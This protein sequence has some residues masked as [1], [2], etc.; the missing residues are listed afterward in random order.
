MP[1]TVEEFNRQ[2]KALKE[3][4]AL[5]QE[6]KLKAISE[7]KKFEQ[8]NRI[9]YLGHD[10]KGYLGKYG[11]WRLNRPQQ[12]LTDKFSTG[13][14]KVMTY[15]GGNRAGKTF[16]TTILLLSCIMGR[17][18]W[19][20]QERMGWIW[21]LYGWTNPIKIRWVGQDW[22]QHIK[23]V[24][25]QTLKELLPK[26][27][28]VDTKKNNVGAENIWE[29]KI[30]GLP[31]GSIE[32]MSNNSDSSVFEGAS[33]HVAAYDEP[34]SRDVRIA[35]ARGL[36]DN[37]GIELFAMT[38]L[39][40]AWV[41]HDIIEKVDEEGNP[42]QTVY[43]VHAE[44]YDNV[45]LGISAEG[46]KQFAK[47]LTDD[48]Q[49]I[50]LKGIP[51]Y[52]QGLVLPIKREVH[53]VDK[54]QIPLHWPVDIS[55]D[56]H[57]KKP[58][59]VLFM[60]TSPQNLKYCFHEIAEHLPPLLLAQAIVRVKQQQNLRI[61][62]VIIDPFAKG[63]SNN[64]NSVYDIMSQELARY[65]MHLETA[66]KDKDHGIIE[67]ISMLWT[68]NKVPMLFFF[69]NLRNAIR[70]IEGWCY[71]ENESGMM[72]PSKKDDDFPET[73]YRLALLDTKYSEPYNKDDEPY[74]PQ[75]KKS[76]ITGY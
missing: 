16:I 26:S 70:Q 37:N 51:S 36:V 30:S 3:K 28:E 1:I 35:C 18:P 45:G 38:L 11:E 56:I 34:P 22:E 27:W 7:V 33:L 67:L 20:P 39:K 24:M 63:D 52:K 6:A 13:K 23:R 55:I 61:N 31:A 48:E 32:I 41:S 60:A 53:L 9:L 42:D 17:F 68:P 72:K 21:R 25:I 10:G 47:S 64:E 73:L 65:D 54:F 49:E 76:G 74:Q 29:F 12:E 4:Q 2:L 15:T 69:R 50:R 62:R 5:L 8:D 66:S 71:E 59:C 14:Y 43:N 19:E 57:P 44:I 40:E 58:Q 75:L 46:V